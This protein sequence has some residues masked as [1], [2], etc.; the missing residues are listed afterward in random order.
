VSQAPLELL[1][2]KHKLR[3]YK[4]AADRLVV[5]SRH[6]QYKVCP[7]LHPGPTIDV[8]SPHR[9]PPRVAVVAHFFFV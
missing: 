1:Q 5:D 8:S 7:T 3:L 6:N 4:W 2:L 9:R